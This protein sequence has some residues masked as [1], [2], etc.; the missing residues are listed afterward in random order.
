MTAATMLTK[1][2]ISE[3]LKDEARNL[4]QLYA[5][6]VQIQIDIRQDTGDATLRV[7]EYNI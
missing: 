7:T 1:R 2:G 6:N 3:N 4:A 5:G